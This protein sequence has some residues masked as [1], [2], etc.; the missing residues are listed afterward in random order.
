MTQAFQTGV[1]HVIA[2]LGSLYCL[3]VG[4]KIMLAILV[5]KS[6]SYLKGSA[7]IYT[8]R[9]LGLALCVFSLF[10]FNEG[11]VLLGILQVS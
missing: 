4:A 3:L 6:K 1:T 8:M 2:F 10:F 9:L 5:G 7:Y 11:M